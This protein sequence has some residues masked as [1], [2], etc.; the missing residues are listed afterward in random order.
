V[1]ST[2]RS[3]SGFGA[4]FMGGIDREVGTW[5]DGTKYIFFGLERILD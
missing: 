5:E 4:R 3:T 1:T 2:R